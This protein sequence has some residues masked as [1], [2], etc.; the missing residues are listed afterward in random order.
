MTVFYTSDPHIHHRLVA[1]FRYQRVFP[2]QVEQDGIPESA[3]DWHDE[4]LAQQWDMVVGKDDVVWVCG[5]LAVSGTKTS[6]GRAL[7]WMAARPGRKHLVPGN[8]DPVHPL[9]RDSH[10][11]QKLYL[12]VFE[13]VQLAARR[14]FAMPD[15][16]A[17]EILLSHLP[18]SGDRDQDDR[19][20][21]WR[22][23]DEG[24]WLLHGHLHGTTPF[25]TPGTRQLDV[26]LDPWNLK[27]VSE[28]TLIKLI[29]V[30]E[31]PN[32]AEVPISIGAVGIR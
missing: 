1:K 29:Y 18:Y 11:W 14:K 20:T 30:L 9:H 22:L 25:H 2:F 7:D 26:G 24:K 21:Q 28:D 13:S 3:L 10:K 12:T 5:D 27:P 4:Y 31:N 16:T 19:E 15:G 8:H 32:Q 17:R 23:R 6:V